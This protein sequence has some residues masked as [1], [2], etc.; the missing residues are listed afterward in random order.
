MTDA[1]N[2]NSNSSEENVSPERENASVALANEFLS[3]ATLGEALSQVP[4]NA[5]LQLAQN[6]ALTQGKEE[7]KNMTDEQVSE[8]LETIEKNRQEAEAAAQ[9]AVDQVNSE[10]A[11]ASK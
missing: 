7:V 8:L 1:N 11:E 6:R 3:R 4:L 5:V 9:Q 2:Q 10:T